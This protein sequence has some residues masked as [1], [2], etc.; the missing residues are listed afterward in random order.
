VG[1][2]WSLVTPAGVTVGAAGIRDRSRNTPMQP[3]D[4]VQV[5]SVAKTL[6]ATGVLMLVT[7]GRVALDAPVT[8]YLP[9]VR[10]D[11]AWERDAPL[12]VRHLLDHTGG[13]A[14]VHL[15]QVFTM[16]GNPDSPLTGNCHLG[17]M[18]TFRAILCVHP[19]HQRAFFASYNSDPE[20]ANW[21]RIDSL[22]ASS[23]GVPPT[24]AIPGAAPSV[25]PSAWNGWAPA[26]CFS[27]R[28][29]ST[30][31][32][33]PSCTSRRNRAPP[34]STCGRIRL[35]IV[36]GRCRWAAARRRAGMRP[37]RS[38]SIA[39]V[40][41]WWRSPPTSRVPSPGCGRR[42]CC[43]TLVAGGSPQ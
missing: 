19:E 22:F 10:I 31:P 4:R 37:A 36:P 21:N 28:I 12:L 9:D 35:S 1:V 11:N 20:E 43:S 32:A 34:R 40:R 3:H 17:N 29:S 13:V 38:S 16:R 24:V 25:D 18:G 6:I 14:D 15:W 33:P 7:D 39:A 5:G 30:G 26:R 41:R 23:L 2:T 8:L 42:W 27:A